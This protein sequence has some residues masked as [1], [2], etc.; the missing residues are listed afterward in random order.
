MAADGTAIVRRVVPSNVDIVQ[1]VFVAFERRDIDALIRLCAPDMVFE[2]VTARVAAGG[3]AYRG[4]DGLRAYLDDVG[5]VWQELRP[6]PD[7]YREGRDGIV[8][9][10]GRVY[11]WGAGRVVDSPA[12]W[13]WR[14]RDGRIV[15]GRIF[16]STSAA[17][18]AVGMAS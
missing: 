11:A 5:R 15:Y 17:L 16:D 13:L 4:H 14:L 7:T 3:E 10:T 9:A 2:P 18:E 12:G 1:E 8:V 6:S